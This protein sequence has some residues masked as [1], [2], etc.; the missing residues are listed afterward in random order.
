MKEKP[1]EVFFESPVHEWFELSYAQYLTIPRSI[2]ESM[3][4][5]WQERMVK[6]LEELNE[7][8][9]WRPTEGRYWVKLKDDKGRYVS[10]PLMEYRHP[11]KNYI[12]SIKK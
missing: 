4:N 3:S 6:C 9:D 11:D 12:K 1:E 10:D 8:F 5:E 2:M 7:T